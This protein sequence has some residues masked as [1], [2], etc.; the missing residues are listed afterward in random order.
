MGSISKFETDPCDAADNLRAN[1]KLTLSECCIPVLAVIFLRHS[2][3][4][5]YAVIRQIEAD[6]ACSKIPMSTPITRA[7]MLNAR[8]Q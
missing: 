3:N 1:S 2:T 7:K 6:K 8:S 4:R 5:Y